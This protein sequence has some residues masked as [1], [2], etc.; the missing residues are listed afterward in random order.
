[1]TEWA[2]III[3]SGIAGIVIVI[4]LMALAVYLLR[5]PK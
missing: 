4:G 3:V 2:F 1:M 5:K